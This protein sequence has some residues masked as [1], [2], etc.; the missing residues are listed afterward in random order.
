MRLFYVLSHRS[1]PSRY[2]V[3]SLTRAG[4]RYLGV[5]FRVGRGGKRWAN[6]RGPVREFITRKAAARALL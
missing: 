2:L 1:A 5:V 6:S 3:Y 4:E